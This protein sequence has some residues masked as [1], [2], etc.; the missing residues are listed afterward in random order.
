MGG[1]LSAEALLLARYYMFMQVYYHP[2]RLAYD[3]HLREFLGEWL[4]EGKFPTDVSK[5]LSLTDVEMIHAMGQAARA[6]DDPLHQLAVRLVQ[7]GHFRQVYGRTDSDLQLHEDPGAV[8]QGALEERYQEESIRRSVISPDNIV[9]DFPVI[10]ARDR[11]VLSAYDNS[12]ILQRI[13]AAKVDYVFVAPEIKSE[14][15]KWISDNKL[16]ILK[17]ASKQADEEAGDGTS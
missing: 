6:P 11:E 4:A 13:P 15:G 2:A 8:I 5:L 1:L 17:Q 10:R 3:I 12:Q 16:A 7:R 9:I 14:A